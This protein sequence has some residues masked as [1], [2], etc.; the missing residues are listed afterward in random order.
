MGKLF[1][2]AA[3]MLLMLCRPEAAANAVIN[4][5]RRK[6]KII[7]LFDVFTLDAS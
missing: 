3:L 4:T 2:G 6:A 7:I 1:V 5:G